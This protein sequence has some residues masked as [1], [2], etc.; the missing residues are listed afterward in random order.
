MLI[1]E[2]M[3]TH[4]GTLFASYVP[5]SV[6]YLIFLNINLQLQRSSNQIIPERM[7]HVPLQIPQQV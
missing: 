4:K 6:K 3:K 2:Y 7:L 1:L 5:G